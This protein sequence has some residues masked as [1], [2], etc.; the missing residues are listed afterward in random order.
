M[1]ET[2][3]SQLSS[4]SLDL[5]ASNRSSDFQLT[6]AREDTKFTRQFQAILVSNFYIFESYL[7]HIQTVDAD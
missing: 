6:G 3:Q 7:E 1:T 5:F 2:L 4:P